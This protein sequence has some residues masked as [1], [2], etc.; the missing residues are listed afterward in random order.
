MSGDA[1]VR[2]GNPVTTSTGCS[3]TA[4]TDP[5]RDAGTGGHPGGDY[6]TSAISWR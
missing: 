4:S 6:P 5:S 2:L 3:G 1:G